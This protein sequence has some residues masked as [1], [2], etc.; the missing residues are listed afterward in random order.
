MPKDKI[1]R[2][3]AVLISSSM[4]DLEEHRKAVFEA[5]LRVGASP[6]MVETLPHTNAEFD[7]AMN[8]TID[9]ADVYIGIFGF[10]YGYIPPGQDRSVMELEYRR[11]V[12]RGIPRLIFVMSDKHPIRIQDVETGVGAGKIKD[13]RAD[14][15]KDNVVSLFSSVDELR[16]QVITTLSTFVRRKKTK[17]LI[18]KPSVKDFDTVQRALS[19]ALTRLD[20]EVVRIDNIK[21]GAIWFNA[22]TDAIQEADFIIADITSANPN[23][24]YELGYA[25]A[26]QKPTILLAESEAIH[27]LPFNLMFYQVVT[28]DKQQLDEFENILPRLLQKYI[29][30]A[31]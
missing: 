7:D 25:H 19:A 1:N 2:R 28:Y 31:R 23:V 4:L 17:V 8:R 27:Q 18:L 3:I 26:L 29:E 20:V 11:V 21:S 16:A 30:S 10:R 15:A 12:E 9:Q 22:I 14:L 6:T 13:F 24:V 5:C